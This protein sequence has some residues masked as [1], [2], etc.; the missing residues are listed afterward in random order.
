MNNET[1]IPS[2]SVDSPAPRSHSARH[3]RLRWV[4]A[5][6]HIAVRKL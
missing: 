1:F 2:F 3:R 6:V 4:P 5:P